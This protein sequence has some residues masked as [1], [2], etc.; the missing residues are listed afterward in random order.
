[1]AG[2]EKLDELNEFLVEES[3]DTKRKIPIGWLILFWGLILWGIYYFASYTPS[4]SGWTQEKA[5]EESVKK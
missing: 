3:E 5:Y 1:M 2:E 4:I